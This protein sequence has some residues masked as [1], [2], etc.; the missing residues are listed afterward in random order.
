MHSSKPGH[1]KKTTRGNPWQDK[2]AIICGASAGLG[3]HLAEELCKQS[4]SKL[5]LI[6]RSTERLE[7]ACQQLR[8]AYP[9]VGFVVESVDMNSESEVK[10]LAER[11]QQAGFTADLLIQAA[12]QSDRGMLCDL[13]RERMLELFDANLFPALNAINL[14]SGRLHQP[15]GTVVL[16]GSLASHFAPRFLGG[17]AMAKH[18]VAALAQQARLEL[19]TQGIHVMLASP[20]PIDRDDAGS[21]YHPDPARPNAANLPTQ[22]LKPG[23]GARLNLLNPQQLAKTI[24]RDAAHRKTLCIQPAKVG[25]LCV[26]HALAPSWAEKLLRKNSS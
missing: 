21:R 9:A 13:T 6:A 11:W 22:A 18:A 16:I 23:G 3:Y 15:G 14:L 10:K 8:S 5:V 24:L 20:G 25:W 1:F 19:A 2:T 4:A 26:L 7:A 12:G 17:Y